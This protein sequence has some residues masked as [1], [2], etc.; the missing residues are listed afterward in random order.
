MPPTGLVNLV[1]GTNP[2]DFVAVKVGDVGSGNF[3][4]EIGNFMM[5]AAI[6][7]QIIGYLIMQK[8]VNIDVN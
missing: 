3:T 2:K 1:Q 8:I 7:L 4:D 6:L 5:G